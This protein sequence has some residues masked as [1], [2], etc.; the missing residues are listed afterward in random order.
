M[1]VKVA[2]VDFD[3]VFELGDVRHVDANGAV[4]ERLHKLVVFQTAIFRLVG[5]ANDHLVDVGLSEL[6]GFDLVLLA[7]A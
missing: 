2:L 5:M 4:F 7:G 3:F 1:V 6:F